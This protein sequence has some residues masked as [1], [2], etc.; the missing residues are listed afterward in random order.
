ME[1][2][3]AINQKQVAITC[4]SETINCYKANYLSDI[5]Y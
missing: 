3:A 4:Q 5:A 1:G 2:A